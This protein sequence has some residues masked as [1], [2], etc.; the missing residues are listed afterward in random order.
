MDRAEPKGGSTELED[1]G[2]VSFEM[3]HVGV[4]CRSPTHDID[5]ERSVIASM[6]VRSDA[7]EHAVIDVIIVRAL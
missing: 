7:D 5:G 6:R 3:A 1:D 2:R 4:T